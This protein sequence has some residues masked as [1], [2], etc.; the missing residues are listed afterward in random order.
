MGWAHY[1]LDPADGH[2]VYRSFPVDTR[3]EEVVPREKLS[4][5]TNCLLMRAPE[6][7]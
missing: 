1:V 3:H 2:P 5:A 6:N 7:E 4:Q